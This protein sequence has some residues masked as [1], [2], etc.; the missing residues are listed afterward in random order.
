MLREQF[1]TLFAYS[2]ATAH[3]LLEKA[4]E[5]DDGAYYEHPGY[6]HGSIHDLFYHLMTTAR[7]W[8]IALETGTQPAR[9][10]RQD[11]ATLAAVAAALEQEA[12]SW[13]RLIGGLRDEQI[14]GPLVLT[15]VRGD[16][17]DLIYWRVLQH[18]VLHAMQHHTEIAKLLTDKGVSPGDID[19]LFYEG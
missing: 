7:G 17:A 10:R 11:F 12:E 19:F 13:Q 15:T 1:Q 2:A 5:L 9:P 8:R 18:L 14:A 4:T 16:R 3:R 6:G